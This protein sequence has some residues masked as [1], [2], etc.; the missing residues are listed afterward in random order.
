[1]PAE[2]PDPRLGYQGS[3][4]SRAKQF[5]MKALVVVGGAT[6]LVSAFLLSMVFLAIGLVVVVISGGYLWWKTRELRKQFRARMREAQ[7]RAQVHTGSGRI[8][9]GEVVSPDQRRQ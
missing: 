7:A 6:M 2:Q 3:P 5:A 9:E 1:M 8:I 4:M